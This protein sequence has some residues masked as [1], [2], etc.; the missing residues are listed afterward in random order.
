ME[1]R[2]WAMPSLATS[3]RGL[4]PG[5]FLALSPWSKAGCFPNGFSSSHGNFHHPQDRVEPQGK[6]SHC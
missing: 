1:R 2:R 4:E 3:M 5:G 6:K